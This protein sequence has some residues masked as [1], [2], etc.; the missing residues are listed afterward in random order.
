VWAGEKAHPHHLTLQLFLI[1][2]WN[3]L[4]MCRIRGVLL[5]FFELFTRYV[6]W[7][8]PMSRHFSSRALDYGR[9]QQ[10]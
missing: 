5:G 1:F 6:F 3:L 10:R 9:S 7:S 4:F 8:V 2:G